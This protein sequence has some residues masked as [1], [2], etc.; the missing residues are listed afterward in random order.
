MG[1]INALPFRVVPA[2][3]TILPYLIASVAQLRPRFCVYDACAPWAFVMAKVLRLPAASCMSALPAEKKVRDNFDAASCGPEA[4]E[5]LAACSAAIAVNYNVEFNT[6]HRYMLYDD[7]T[8]V[9][10]SR[11]WHKA[12]ALFPEPQFRYWGTL[13]SERKG[14]INDSVD[15][16]M[17]AFLSDRELGLTKKLVFAS[18]G[19]VATGAGFALFGAAATDYYQKLC[20]AAAKLPDVS[21]VFAVG[22]A[23]DLEE[24]EGRVTKLFGE[25]VPSNVLVARK[26]NQPNLLQ[27]CNLFLTHCGQNSAMETIACA[28]PVI[29]APFFGD[30]VPN[31]LRFKD[32]GCGIVISYHQDIDSMNAWGWNPNMDLVTPE[33]LAAGIQNV[34]DDSAYLEAIRALNARQ[35]AEDLPMSEKINKLVAYADAQLPGPLFARRGGC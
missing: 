9:C 20:M 12:N 23:A 26:V 14:D 31:A 27:R 15:E 22:S 33:N 35:E 32:L 7:Q 28:V 24:G 13:L 21:F 19:T 3:L 4:R 6:N 10:A 17:K 34:L 30:Q 5:V 2:T 1:E 8:I 29:C 11:A 18:L 25:L 16:A